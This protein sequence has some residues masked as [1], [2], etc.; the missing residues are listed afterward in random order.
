MFY[1]LSDIKIDNNYN[2]VPQKGIKNENQFI[3]DGK[4]VAKAV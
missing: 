3:S 1:T 2:F 4:D